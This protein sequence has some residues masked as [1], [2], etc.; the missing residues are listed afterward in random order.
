MGEAG[1]SSSAVGGTL[2]LIDFGAARDFP[3]VFVQD[4]LEM[5]KVSCRSVGGRL[6]LLVG[7]ALVV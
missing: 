7:T 2:H 3:A 1:G 6:G 4:Y 5:V